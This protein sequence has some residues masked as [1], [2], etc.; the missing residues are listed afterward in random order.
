MTTRVSDERET[1]GLGVVRI[2]HSITCA[3][4]MRLGC[5]AYFMAV[6]MS[7]SGSKNEQGRLPSLRNG[8]RR[9]GRMVL[10]ARPAVAL[11]WGRHGCLPG[12]LL[13]AYSSRFAQ[14]LLCSTW[15]RA[16]S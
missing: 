9:V 16:C 14:S 11:L 7:L 13:G 15:L 6:V 12:C 3:D 2:A 8:S 4:A 1:R 10:V 5:T